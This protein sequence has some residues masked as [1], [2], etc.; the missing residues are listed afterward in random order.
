MRLH[1]STQLSPT[2]RLLELHTLDGAPFPFVAGQYVDL[3]VPT[4]GL[5]EKRPYSIASAPSQH[6]PHAFELAVTLIEDGPASTALHHLAVGARLE[7][8]GPHGRFV[9]REPHQ[10]Q[11]FVGAGTGLSPLRAMIHSLLEDDGHPELV[12]LFGCRDEQN[13]LWGEELS[14]AAARDPRFRFH[15]TLSRGSPG[16]S[17]L[18]GYVQTHLGDVVSPLTGPRVYVCGL[19]EMVQQCRDVLES[20][21]GLPPV[22]VFSEEYI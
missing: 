10:P 9:I 3:F 16:W 4:A 7:I 22:W 8:D 13:I 15:P 20:T 2:V 14:A 12:L 1:A 17:G 11:V 19:P 5:H 21:L 6:A 18:R